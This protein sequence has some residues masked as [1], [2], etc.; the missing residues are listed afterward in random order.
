MKHSDFRGAAGSELVM[1][2]DRLGEIMARADAADAVAQE[3][4]EAQ[5]QDDIDASIQAA[6]DEKAKVLQERGQRRA[7]ALWAVWRA[8]AQDGRS[9]EPPTAHDAD[10]AWLIV[11]ML[12]QVAGRGDQVRAP[13]ILASSSV[14]T[15]R[16]VNPGIEAAIAQPAAQSAVAA[17]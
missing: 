8:K 12:H 11:D 6:T 17:E 13:S 2:D 16:A 5:A 14:T 4:A 9:G 15:G 3:A 7:D 1:S 10:T